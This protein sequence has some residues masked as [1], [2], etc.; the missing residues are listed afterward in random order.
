VRGQAY[1]SRLAYE[2]AKAENADTSKITCRTCRKNAETH[3]WCAKHKLGRAGT[4]L[5]RD[6]GEYH[7]LEKAIEILMLANEA[8]ARCEDCS[9]AIIT[10][11]VCPVC[12][13]RY[14]DGRPI[15]KP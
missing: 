14:K 2:L 12:R 15:D 1:Y 3:G 8:T 5:V 13:T 11:G 7:R 10:D 4:F 9:V 6:E